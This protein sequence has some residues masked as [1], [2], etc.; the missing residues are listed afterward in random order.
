MKPTTFGQ[1]L[2][3]YLLDV[4]ILFP[5]G[6]TPIVAA[7]VSPELGVVLR[8]LMTPLGFLYAIYFIANRGQTIGKRLMKIKVVRIDENAVSVRDAFMRGLIDFAFAAGLSISSFVAGMSILSQR[9]DDAGTLLFKE[10]VDLLNAGQNEGTGQVISILSIVY[11]IA[12]LI[13][14]FSNPERRFIHDLVANTKVVQLSPRSDDAAFA[15]K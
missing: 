2:G 13:C 1:R 7:Y 11:A 10:I 6:L 5:L 15:A 12:Q 8:L 9:G 3:A 4:I 14:F